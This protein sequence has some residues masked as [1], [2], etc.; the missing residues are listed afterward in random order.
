MDRG[1]ITEIDLLRGI[2]IIMMAVFHFC[3]DLNYFRIISTA[4][5][6]LF[7]DIFQK[8]TG[9][10]FI[11][12]VGVSLTLSYSRTMKKNPQQYPSK[13]LLRGIRIFFYGMIIT[14]VSYIFMREMFVFF[15]ILHFIGASIVIVT[16]FIDFKWLNLFLGIITLSIGIY[17]TKFLFSFAWL[18]WLGFRYPVGTLDLYPI[19]PW[20]GIVFFGLFA[21]NMIY[22]KGK[23]IFRTKH[24]P[25]S[26]SVEFLG[27]YSLL[28]YFLHLPVMFGAA[29]LIHLLGIFG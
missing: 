25:R 2:A 23:R 11:F 28:I 12:L 19:L 24:L 15:G 6:P 5:H 3:W 18:I 10:L 22:P 14:I 20:I 21:G 1:R 7:W 17:L 4:S 9:G 13:Y 29:Y 26:R 16:P 27:R 8:L